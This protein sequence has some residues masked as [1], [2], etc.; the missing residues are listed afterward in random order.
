MTRDSISP[1][2]MAAIDGAS[3][4]GGRAV[5]IARADATLSWGDGA[6]TQSFPAARWR[7][8]RLVFSAAMRIEAPRIGTG[9][10]LVVT[11]WPKRKEGSHDTPKPI[12]AYQPDGPVRSSEWIRR[13]VAVDIPADAERLQ[14]SLVAT[15]N[16]ASWF[17][18]LEL[19]AA[20]AERG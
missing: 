14:I 2:V 18:D 3:P 9:A 13:S 10:Q 6:L 20:G 12:L 16:S 15:G 4:R 19:A 7:G 1:H 11:V 5:R 17:G 8:Q